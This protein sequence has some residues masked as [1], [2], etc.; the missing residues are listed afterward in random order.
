MTHPTAAK[1]AF[2][3]STEVGK[4]IMRSLAGTGTRR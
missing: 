4:I 2:T 1:V 3:G